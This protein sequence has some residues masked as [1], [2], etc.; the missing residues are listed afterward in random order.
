M[1]K[2]ILVAND[3]SEGALEATEA[4]SDIAV[5]Y[6][7]DLVMVYVIPERFLVDGLQRYAAMEPLRILDD[8]QTA[9]IQKRM[10]IMARDAAQHD[11]TVTKSSE[12]MGQH[13]LAIGERL[14]KG[15][16]V[17]QIKTYLESGNPAREILK[18]VEFSNADLIVVG[19]SGHSAAHVTSLGST[20][21]KI[22]HRSNCTCLVVGGRHH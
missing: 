7:A 2:T 12:H 19:R 11:D 17:K 6:D 8:V 20:A 5:K 22:I 1:F 14:A 18:H 3:G 4:A 9:D 15:K 16:G 10:E 21:D 13:V